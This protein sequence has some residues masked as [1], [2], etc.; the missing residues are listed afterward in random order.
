MDVGSA[1]GFIYKLPFTFT[2]EIEQVTV[3]LK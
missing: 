1:G 3:G 2:G